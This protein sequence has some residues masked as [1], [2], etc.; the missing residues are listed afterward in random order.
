VYEND[1]F[2]YAYGL[3][4]RLF[5]RPSLGERGKAIAYYA[6][7]TLT[8]GGSAFIVMSPADIEKIRQRSRAKDDGPWKTDYDAMARKTCLRQ[9]FK[10]LPK[11]AVLAQAMAQDEGVRTDWSEDALDIQPE[12]PDAVPGEVERDHPSDADAGLQVEDPPGWNGEDA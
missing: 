7:A 5:H 10:L 3:E 8:N 1:D 4:P 6:V 11:S 9:L 12:Y 2:D